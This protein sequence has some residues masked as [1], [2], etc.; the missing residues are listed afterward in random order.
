MKRAVFLDRDGVINSM[1]YHPEF[2]IVDSPANPDEFTMLAGVPD[3]IKWLG[4]MGFLTVV[5]SNQPG[6]AKGKMTNE[7][8]KATMGKMENQLK[9]R[10]ATLDGIYYCLHHPQARLEEF[11]I[12]CDCRKPKPGLLVQA[13][14]DLDIS[15]KDSY[16]IGDGITDIVAGKIAGC[17]TILV[18][19]RK[20]YLCDELSRQQ[21]EPDYIAKDLPDAARLI[22]KIEV[23]DLTTIEHYKFC[24]QLDS[25]C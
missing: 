3:A 15:L 4:E 2:G 9:A 11:R 23:G 6:V 1:V 8:L 10:G 25:E 18:N 17:S 7:L 12:I 19:S 13:A 21:V 5:I 14:A 24:C 20:C 16:F 22:Q